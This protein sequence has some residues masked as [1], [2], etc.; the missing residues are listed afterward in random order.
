MVQI[1]A[2]LKGKTWYI[3]SSKAIQSAVS[4]V[5]RHP[6]RG[7]VQALVTVVEE[8]VIT[9]WTSKLVQSVQVT[10]RSADVPRLRL[11][12]AVVHQDAAARGKYPGSESVVALAGQA[13]VQQYLTQAVAKVLLPSIGA[14]A[15][16]RR[17]LLHVCLFGQT[18]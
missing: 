6:E 17:L 8:K 9:F 12:L 16:F 5:N 4:Y 14:R 2:L 10:I 1:Q 18:C 13:A 15:T 11:R 3:P 7:G